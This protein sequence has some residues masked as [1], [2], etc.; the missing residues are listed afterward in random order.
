[1]PKMNH[2][3]YFWEYQFS[4]E[5]WHKQFW[6]WQPHVYNVASVPWKL[7]SH[8]WVTAWVF[9]IL[10]CNW[11]CSQPNT[12]FTCLH[13]TR[14]TEIN[15]ESTSMVWPTL[16]SRTA[17]EQNRTCILLLLKKI[18]AFLQIHEWSGIC[19]KHNETAKRPSQLHQIFVET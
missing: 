2:I 18:L 14:M 16:G 6:S 3:E 8:F 15:G 17:K 10:S 12:G 19:W 4:D 11:K 9:N 1:M 7:Q 13:V 5:I